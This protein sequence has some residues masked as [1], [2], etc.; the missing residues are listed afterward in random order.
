MYSDGSQ[1]LLSH[2]IFSP[3]HR[4]SCFGCVWH[5]NRR[6]TNIQHT[7][8]EATKAS[9][10]ETLKETDFIDLLFSILD[11]KVFFARDVYMLEF[12]N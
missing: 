10:K 6:S 2:V 11:G 3:L 9:Q 4:M 12:Y 5:F 8:R 1:M 7:E